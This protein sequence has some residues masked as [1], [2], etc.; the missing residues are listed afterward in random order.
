MNKKAAMV[1]LTMA[2]LGLLG[3]ATSDASASVC[4]VET[5][6]FY[7]TQYCGLQDRGYGQ[8]TTLAGLKTLSA[9]LSGSGAY[10]VGAV[11]VNSSGQLLS[12]CAP[13]DTVADGNPAYAV[14]GDCLNAVKFWL[15]I[16]YY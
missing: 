3:T 7:V 2:A 8:G 6:S 9:N 1:V 4:Q 13:Y 11:G 14:G 5:S 16:D 10:Q 15:E 12:H